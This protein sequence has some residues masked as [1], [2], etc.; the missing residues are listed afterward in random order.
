MAKAVYLIVYALQ[1]WWIDIDGRSFGPFFDKETAMLDAI[2]MARKFGDP[3]VQIELW[4]PD[5]GGRNRVMWKGYR[6]AR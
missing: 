4:A 1:N 5:E 3:G 6:A 2:E